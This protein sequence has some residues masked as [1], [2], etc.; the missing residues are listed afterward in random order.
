L[1]AE[2]SEEMRKK[3]ELTTFCIN[4][5]NFQESSAR[6]DKKAVEFGVI[7]GFRTLIELTILWSH[8]LRVML[9]FWSLFVVF[10]MNFH[11]GEESDHF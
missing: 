4:F 3:K 6:A 5:L 1:A 10:G 8:H 7:L 9:M 11:I 2:K